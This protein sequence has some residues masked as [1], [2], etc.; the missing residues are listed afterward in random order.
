MARLLPAVHLPLVPPHHRALICTWLLV[1]TE[2]NRFK[3]L[4]VKLRPA[5]RACAERGGNAKRLAP[6]PAPARVC[7]R[8]RRPAAGV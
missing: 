2:C 7:G 1:Y 3:V 5:L 8:V 4:V 6:A